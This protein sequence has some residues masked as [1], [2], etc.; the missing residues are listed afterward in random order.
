MK[1]DG[2]VTT[3]NDGTGWFKV[4]NFRIELIEDD[5]TTIQNSKIEIQNSKFGGIYDL[6]GRRV[7]QQ[8]KIQ[9]S[10]SKEQEGSS[11]FTFHSS[12]KKG[13]CIVNGKKVAF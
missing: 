7:A 1:S 4:D 12:L 2:T 5:A 13:L 3:T 11:F 10:K 9:N 8:F 6:S